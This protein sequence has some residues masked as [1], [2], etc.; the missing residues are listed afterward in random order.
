[1]SVERIILFLLTINI[2]IHKW[3]QTGMIKVE[4]LD[5]LVQTGKIKVE[6]L[7]YLVQTGIR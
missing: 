4:H 5:Y 7:D 6:H 1:M 3:V 2:E